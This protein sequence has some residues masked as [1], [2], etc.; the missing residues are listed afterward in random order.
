MWCDTISSHAQAICMLSHVLRVKGS[1]VQKCKGK[2]P[3]DA[4]KQYLM[5]FQKG[6]MKNESRKWVSEDVVE[7]V[8]GIQQSAAASCQLSYKKQ[9]TEQLVDVMPSCA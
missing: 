4:H 7:T 1:G 5:L 6:K 8:D 2:L 9:S 3:P